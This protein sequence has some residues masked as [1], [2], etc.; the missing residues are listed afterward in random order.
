MFPPFR[1]NPKPVS[2]ARHLYEEIVSRAR[3]PIFHTEFAV[4]DTLDGRFD[5]LA[6]HASVV[7][8][9]LKI[10][11]SPAGVIGT[12]LASLIFAGF[13]DALRQMGVSDFGIGR[14]IKAMAAAF[15]GR[16]EVYGGALGENELAPA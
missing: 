6:L 4:P 9:A 3:Q 15:Y 14:R 13:D 7:M 16:L 1:R 5:V 10:L 11:G 8:D 2:P 12:D